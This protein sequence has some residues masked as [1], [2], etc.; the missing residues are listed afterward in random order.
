MLGIGK[1]EIVEMKEV[2]T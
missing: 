1:H 2:K